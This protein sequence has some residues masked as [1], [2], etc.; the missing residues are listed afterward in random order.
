M[1]LLQFI[2]K[3]TSILIVMFK[4]KTIKLNDL[5]YSSML[6]FEPLPEPNY[7]P[8]NHDLNKIESAQSEDA[9]IVLSP[10]WACR[11]MRRFLKNPFYISILNFELFGP[12][13]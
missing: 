2:V 10:I 6:K 4:R 3:L 1:K 5:F 11:F 8:K 7:W 9:W 13:I 12:S